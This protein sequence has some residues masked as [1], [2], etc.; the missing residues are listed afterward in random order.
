M[1]KVTV[2][3]FSDPMMGLAWECEPALRRVCERFGDGVQIDERMVVLVRDVGDFMTPGERA[4]P[5]EAGIR[6]YNERLAQIYLDEE[7]IAGMPINMEGFGLFGPGRRSSRPLCLACEAAKTACPD[8]SADFLYR[9][10]KATVAEGRVTTR[11]DVLL[12][13]AGETG[14]D[15]GAF[16]AAFVD[17]RSEAAL[18][19]DMRFAS[20]V[21]VRSLPAF[22]V[23]C[24][25]R[26][27]MLNG[28]PVNGELEEAV[29]E[30]SKEFS[31]P[32]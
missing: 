22:L 15:T 11:E 9:L 14:L 8:K 3:R 1:A 7:P 21:G 20:S 23:T 13:L 12:E 25:E 24:G 30:I 18:R 28:L 5:E 4:M 19:Q 27:L 17:G 32:A 26:G 29:A 10:R 2:T 31:S 16:H 6:A